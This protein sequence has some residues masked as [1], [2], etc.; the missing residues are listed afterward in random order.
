M[1]RVDSLLEIIQFKSFSTGLKPPR[2]HRYALCYS[3]HRIDCWCWKRLNVNSCWS[4]HKWYS[5]AMIIKST[6]TYHEKVRVRLQVSVF[7]LPTRS[8]CQI[9]VAFISIC[10]KNTH[11][12]GGII[13]LLL[14]QKCVSKMVTLTSSKMCFKNGTRN[15]HIMNHPTQ[16]VGCFMMW[17]FQKTHGPFQFLCSSPSG[18]HP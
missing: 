6:D 5:C 18:Q 11:C 16:L 12:A 14:F 2:P 15:T 17:V 8:T 7:F 9:L 10:C 13:H 4:W 1:F 3:V